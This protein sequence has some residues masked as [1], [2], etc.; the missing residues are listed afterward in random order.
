MCRR[1]EPVHSSA[2]RRG[3]LWFR[4]AV[5]AVIALLIGV[6]A[7]A[8]SL[9]WV[10]SLG[11]FELGFDAE[12][13]KS[14]SIRTECPG[15]YTAIIAARVEPES[16]QIWEG[17]SPDSPGT[18]S[19]VIR[20][21]PTD[22]SMPAFLCTKFWMETSSR[23]TGQTA[24]V[25]A[26]IGRGP[27]EVAGQVKKA[28]VENNGANNR[29]EFTFSVVNPSGDIVALSMEIV[30]HRMAV[31][32]G[33]GKKIVSFSYE[34]HGDAVSPTVQLVLPFSFE[35]N[36]SFPAGEELSVRSN[37]ATLTLPTRS[38]EPIGAFVTD[39]SMMEDKEIVLFLAAAMLGTGVALMAEFFRALARLFFA[40]PRGRQID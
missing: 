3:R 13:I 4:A 31:G 12:A 29:R 11:F 8:L 9:R 30:F 18:L 20:H 19:V 27:E 15:K 33:Y 37:G 24:T 21:D 32:L 1:N 38:G 6:G 14:V 7:L 26:I 25:H 40:E 28:P 23:E 35:V 5:E 10:A 16:R 17:E 34:P 36:S 22:S 2:K 39:N